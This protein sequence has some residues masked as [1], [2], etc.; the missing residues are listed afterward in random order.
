MSTRLDEVLAAGLARMSVAPVPTGVRWHYQKEA[1]QLIINAAKGLVQREDQM[2]D[3]E[4]HQAM[5]DIASRI[6]E[7]NN[8]PAN[9]QKEVYETVRKY[10]KDSGGRE[11]KR[12]SGVV[13]L[14]K[15]TYSRINELMNDLVA[16]Q[17]SMSDAEVHEELIRIT[18]AVMSHHNLPASR[19]GNVEEAVKAARRR[20]K[21][22]RPL[23]Q[24]SDLAAQ[25]VDMPEPPHDALRKMSSMQEQLDA[26]ERELEAL[27]GEKAMPMPRYI[28]LEPYG[29]MLVAKFFKDPEREGALA[30][31]AS[32]LELSEK[33]AMTVVE[34]EQKRILK[35][36]ILNSDAKKQWP[37][38]V[39]KQVMAYVNTAERVASE[40]RSHASLRAMRERIASALKITRKELEMRIGTE[41]KRRR[42]ALAERN[43]AIDLQAR[44]IPGSGDGASSSSDAGGSRW[45]TTAMSMMTLGKRVRNAANSPDFQAVLAYEAR[46]PRY[47]EE[48]KRSEDDEFVRDLLDTPGGE[49]NAWMPDVLDLWNPTDD[50]DALNDYDALLADEEGAL[51]NPLA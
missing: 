42:V 46:E 1:L 14:P 33:D 21:G 40:P 10:R 6:R 26:T 29:R 9:K 2:N 3:G 51:D 20:V 44:A 7:E 28:Y 25:P 50:Y 41:Q 12:H 18:H 8:I 24:H 45:R 43:S 5:Q 22:Y 35:A 49:N 32:D 39:Y 11:I 16:R 19:W 34:S 30:E 15:E 13:R 23:A 37:K 48:L 17:E 47:A 4:L 31:L 27:L 36:A 38:E